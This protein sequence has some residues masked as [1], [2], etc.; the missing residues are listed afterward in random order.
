MTVAINII[1]ILSYF[2]TVKLFM[3][4]TP[5]PPASRAGPRAP[6]KPRRYN[7]KRRSLSDVT[8]TRAEDEDFYMHRYI[9][10]GGKNEPEP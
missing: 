5:L 6:R 4:V 8:A 10:F 1:F 9:D 3:N 2:V 7:K